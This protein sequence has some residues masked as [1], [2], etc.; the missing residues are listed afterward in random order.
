MSLPLSSAMRIALQYLER[1]RDQGN[2]P[3]GIAANILDSPYIADGQVWMDW[4]TADALE[5]RGL[6]R[7]EHT[8][9]VY[10]A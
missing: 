7:V 8:A 1:A 2:E 3:H 6:V 9:D 10:L 4:R 5:R